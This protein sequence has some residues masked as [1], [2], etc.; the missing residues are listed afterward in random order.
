MSRP[1][2]IITKLRFLIF[3]MLTRLCYWEKRFC[4]Y[5]ERFFFIFTKNE[6][7]KTRRQCS[8]WWF[9]NNLVNNRSVDVL[10]LIVFLHR[11]GWPLGVSKSQEMKLFQLGQVRGLSKADDLLNTSEC[12][13]TLNCLLL[14]IYNYYYSWILFA[15]SWESFYCL[16]C[17]RLDFGFSKP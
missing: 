7:I 12:L 15:F 10:K 2:L 4:T 1:T 8:R 3:P 6:A 17:L 13:S 11:F 16:T 9:N 14:T 5:L